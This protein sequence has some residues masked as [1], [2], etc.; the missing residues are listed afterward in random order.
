MDIVTAMGRALVGQRIKRKQK[1]EWLVVTD[2]GTELRW[3]SNRQR[4]HLTVADIMAEDWISEED[5]VTVSKY[6]VEE[7]LL[8]LT[9][10]TKEDEERKKEFFKH[11]G[12]K[13]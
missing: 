1:D 7:A 11:L 2:A 6:Q 4:A 13:W 10:L 12:F 8:L 9:D 3:V 5:M